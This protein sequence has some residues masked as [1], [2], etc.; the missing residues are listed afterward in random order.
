MAEPITVSLNWMDVFKILV[1]V[2][3]GGL[4]VTTA[5]IK[6]LDRKSKSIDNMVN[7]FSSLVTNHIQHSDELMKET[8]EKFS[9]IHHKHEIVH[10]KQIDLLEILVDR[11]NGGR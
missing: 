4:A 6:F 5:W 11:I 3:T 8:V 7:Q 2:V 9:E 10:Q 1:V